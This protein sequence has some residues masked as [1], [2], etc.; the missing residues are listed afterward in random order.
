MPTV[1]RY[2]VAVSSVLV[3]ML[4]VLAGCTGSSAAGIAE[5]LE[6]RREQWRLDRQKLVGLEAGLP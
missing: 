4:V 3:L 5:R 1:S 2:V 6:M